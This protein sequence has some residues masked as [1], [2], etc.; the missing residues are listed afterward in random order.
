LQGWW[1]WCRLSSIVNDILSITDEILGLRDDLGAIKHHVFIITR[2]WSGVEIGD[3]TPNDSNV[4]ILPTPYLVDYSHSLRIR[5]GGKIKEG[6]IILKMVSKQSYPDENTI[7]CKVNDKKTEKYYYINGF[8]YEVISITSDYV[9]W[10]VQIRK[11]S[12]QTV[13][14]DIVNLAYALEDSGY[15]LTEDGNYIGLEE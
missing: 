3:G 4:Q 14:L 12:K 6:D 15:F 5:E 10:N 1:G 11:T 7:N 13:Y 8:L 2:T 9:Y